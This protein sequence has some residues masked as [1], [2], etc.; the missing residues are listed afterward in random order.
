MKF[1]LV[2]LFVIIS[3]SGGVFDLDDS[4]LAELDQSCGSRDVR[5][6]VK[7]LTWLENCKIV[8]GHVRISNIDSEKINEF[9]FPL[10]QHVTDFILLDNVASL[11]SVS[12]LFPNLT[13][14][15]GERTF[16]GSSLIIVNNSDLANLGLSKLQQI[17]N[18]DVKIEENPKLCFVKTIKWNVIAVG[19][20]VLISVRLNECFSNFE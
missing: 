9:S 8:F 15:Q 12:S 14:I 2:I 13:T 17:Q 10:L 7:F 3:G 16:R 20:R 18:G 6:D 4:V 1:I 5:F 19:A 11:K